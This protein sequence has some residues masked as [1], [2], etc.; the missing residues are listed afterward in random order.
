MKTFKLLLCLVC[1]STA[2]AWGAD[3]TPSQEK[4]QRALYTYLYKE[5]FDPAVDDSDNSV[6]FRSKNGVLYWVNFDQESPILYTFHRNGF[7]IGTDDKSY[8]R[9]PAII[10]ANEVNQKLTC[11]KV[12]VGEKRVNIVTQV[13][14]SQPENFI[15]VFRKYFDELQKADAEFQRA[16]DAALQMENEAAERLEEEM[17]KNL[18]PS[19]LENMVTDME[20]RILDS[21]GKPVTEYNDNMRCYKAYFVQPRI[22]FGPWK[23]QAAEFEI[24]VRFINP[25]GEIMTYKGSKYVI[26]E[27]IELKKSKKDQVF[28]LQ[29]YGS[30]ENGFWKAGEYKVEVYEGG[31]MIYDT[32]FN[33]L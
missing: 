30:Q 9:N 24:K 23:D 3:L 27:D 1:L 33:M 29:E 11:V 12:T 8:K 2:A 7:K 31:H 21:D 16:Y 17:R 5:K 26:E 22:T 25:K 20:F 10:A 14:A 6:S 18:P 32:R 15:S 28:E 19:E 13:Y 4:A